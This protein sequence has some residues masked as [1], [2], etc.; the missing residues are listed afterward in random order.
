MIGYK[1]KVVAYYNRRVRS[2][3]VL[4]GDL[5]MR[6]RQDPPMGNLHHPEDS[7]P[8]R[9]EDG[10]PQQLGDV[11]HGRP[12]PKCHLGMFQKQLLRQSGGALM[13]ARVSIAQGQGGGGRLKKKR[14][15]KQGQRDR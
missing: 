1:Q 15:V 12:S 6:A 8:A 11:A 9:K 4:V 3:K 13:K 5:V 14:R 2:R 10:L 7:G